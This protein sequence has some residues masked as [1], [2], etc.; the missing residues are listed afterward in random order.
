MYLLADNQCLTCVGSR[1]VPSPPITRRKVSSNVGAMDVSPD[2]RISAPNSDSVRAY[3]TLC[4]DEPDTRQSARAAP[5]GFSPGPSEGPTVG[6]P[7]SRPASPP[8][9]GCQ[10]VRRQRGHAGLGRSPCGPGPR[11][12]SNHQ[13]RRPATGAVATASCAA[14]RS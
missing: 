2:L 5:G 11:A 13:R 4:C 14:S 12:G 7:E 10:R 1:G 8:A 6:P 3:P 9:V